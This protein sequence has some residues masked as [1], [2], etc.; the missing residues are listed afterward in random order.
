MYPKKLKSISHIVE[1][2]LLRFLQ[3]LVTGMPRKTA[4]HFGSIFGDI[5]YFAGV[6]RNVVRINF[7][8][9]GLW[10]ASE[11]K[12]ITRKLYRNMG[13]YAVDFLRPP[14]PIPPHEIHNFETIEPYLS[15]GKGTIVI[16]GHLGNWEMLSTVFGKKTGRLHV[17]AKPMNN[18]IVDKWLLAKRTASSVKTI[19]TDN[20]L[21]KMVE[22]LK[23]DGIIAILIDQYSYFHGTPALFLGKEAKTVRTVAGLAVKMG[24]SVISTN[25]IIRPDGRYDINM[26]ALP[27]PDVAGLSEEQTV[28]VYQQLHNDVIS[29]QIISNPDHWFGWFHR[30]FRE[31]IDYSR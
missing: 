7:N 23:A 6:Y 1:Y 20:A 27:K 3:M 14:Y 24:C 9:V 17:V 15:L 22:T 25:A 4:L 8:H 26:I 30:R 11:Q 19:Y 10:N 12:H 29:R 2:G 5:L 31:Y 21:R 28:S 13:K 16:L 18:T